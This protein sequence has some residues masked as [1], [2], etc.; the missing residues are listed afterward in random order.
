[1][2]SIRGGNSSK[3]GDGSQDIGVS[4]EPWRESNQD[5]IAIDF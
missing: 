5:Q 1:M 3:Q 2:L 4:S